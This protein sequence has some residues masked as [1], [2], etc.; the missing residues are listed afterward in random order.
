MNALLSQ[1]MRFSFATERWHAEPFSLKAKRTTWSIATD[2]HILLAVKL[3]GAKL[4][5]DCPEDLKDML[6]RPAVNPIEISLSELKKWSGGGPLSLVPG[7]EVVF[8]HQG[9]LLDHIIDRR[10]L[11]YLF[12]KIT[13]SKIRAWVAKPGVLGFEQLNGQWRA[14]L[15]ACEDKPRGDEPIFQVAEIPADTMSALDLA[16]LV[17]SE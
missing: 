5:D 6:S 9:V 7:G 1:L 13:T 17:G 15:A 10:K 12:D 11:A 8:E 2:N 3:S 4:S 14:F 16:E